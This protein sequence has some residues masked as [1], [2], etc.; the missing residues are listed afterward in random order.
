MPAFDA[1]D[2]CVIL[3]NLLDNAI[4]AKKTKINCAKEVRLSISIVGNYLH[5][6]VQNRIFES[7]LQKNKALKTSKSDAKL[8]GFG[9]LSVNETV[10]KHDG[11][12]S[13][14]KKMIGFVADVMVKINQ[15]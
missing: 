2:M 5:I 12:M 3:S 1:V 8:H 7:V 14:T 11:M 15:N 4:E 13:F 6:T 9:I 10:A